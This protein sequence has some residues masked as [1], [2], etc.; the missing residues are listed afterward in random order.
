[1]NIAIGSVQTT[2]KVPH[3][4]ASSS[5]AG[6]TAAARRWD[7]AVTAVVVDHIRPRRDGGQD[8]PAN[9]RLL[10]RRCD[11][12]IKERADGTRRSRGKLTVPGCDARGRP[13][14]PSHWWK[15]R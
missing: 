1:M 9:L 5:S 14:D 12:R 11:N 7:V 2:V 15:R 4:R 6:L 10:C 3:G 13:V 8:T